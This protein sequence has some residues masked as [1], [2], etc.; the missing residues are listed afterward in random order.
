MAL[1]HMPHSWSCHAT[2]EIE[3]N[4]GALMAQATVWKD[5][6]QFALLHNYKV[7]LPPSKTVVC[8]VIHPITNAKRLQHQ[9]L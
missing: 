3:A 5:K 6:K 4:H 9:Q 1:K 7:D 8:C 2:R